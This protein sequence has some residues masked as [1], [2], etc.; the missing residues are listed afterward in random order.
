MI[1]TASLAYCYDLLVL[2]NL[3]YYDS[4]LLLLLNN[5]PTNSLL[6]IIYVLGYSVDYFHKNSERNVGVILQLLI[7]AIS[8]L[9]SAFFIILL[10]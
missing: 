8:W 7:S 5:F 2:A 3:I 1:E 6:W 4:R 10:K 9:G